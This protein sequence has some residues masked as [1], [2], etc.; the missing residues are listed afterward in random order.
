MQM[1]T[2]ILF[3]CLIALEASCKVAIVNPRTFTWDPAVMAQT[4]TNV[5]KGDP[6]LMPAVHELVSQAELSM[7]YG[8]WSVMDKKYTPPSGSKHD[9]MSIGTYYWPCNWNQTAPPLAGCN[10]TTGLPWIRRDGEMNPMRLEYDS[11]PL[12]SMATNATVLGLAYYF[13]GNESYANRAAMIITRWF[14]DPSTLMNPNMMYA[15]A[16]PGTNDGFY[17]GIIDSRPFIE[18]GGVINAV[19]LLEGSPSWPASKDRALQEWFKQYD[20]WLLTS[21]AG[22]EEVQEVNNHGTWYDVQTTAYAL[23]SGDNSSA[24]KICTLAPGRRIAPQVQPNGTLPYELARTKAFWYTYFAIEAFFE[25]G[26]LCRCVQVDLFNFTT[27]DGRSIRKALDFIVPYATGK[28]TWPY[29]QIIPFDRGVFFPYFRR[30][31]IIW[32]DLAYETAI[33]SLPDVDYTGDIT[34]LEFPK[35]QEE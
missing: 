18:Y 3:T 11:Y 26:S 14:L 12:E 32:S 1:I 20:T 10:Q 34:N 29:Q 9:Y 2:T 4:K 17:G 30:A 27:S 15:Q 16:Q 24:K 5:V 23:Y 13:T 6:T 25:L 35:Y 19:A 28:M 33:L 8:P 21:D 31:A 22:K 7:L